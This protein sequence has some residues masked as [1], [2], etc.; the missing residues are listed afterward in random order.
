MKR[1]KILAAA[2]LSAVLGAQTLLMTACGTDKAEEK[3]NP[4]DGVSFEMSDIKNYKT[5]DNGAFSEYKNGATELSEYLPHQWEE[6]GAGDP[7]V[8]RYNGMYYLYVS[9]RDRE[10]GVMGWKSSDML[11]WAPCQGDG[12]R[13]GFVSEDP[14]TT[15]AYAPEVYYFNGKFYMATSPAGGGHY[16]LRAD[17]PEGPFTPIT[18]NYGLSIDGSFFV[19]DDESIYFLNAGTGGI[20]IN[21]MDDFTSTPQRKGATGAVASLGWTEGPMMIKRGDYYYLT[22][23]GS[24]V[25]SPGYKVCY[26]TVK[27]GQSIATA[28]AYQAGAGNPILLTVDTDN[29]FKGLGHSSTVLGPDM[30]SHYIIYHTLDMT[31]GHGPWRS[32]NIDRLIFNGTQMSV[33]SSKTDSVA[34]NLP[35]FAATGTTGDNAEKFETAG[36]MTLSKSAT[37]SVFTAEFNFKGNNVKN[38]VSYV[39]ENNYAYVQTDY[40]AKT[41]KLNKVTGG[42]AAEVASGTLKNDFDPDV[43]HTVRVAYADGKADVY[44][45]NMRKIKDVSVTLAAGKVGYEGGIEYA[46]TA[47]SNVARGYSDRKEL[48]QNDLAIG[49]S[50]YLPEGAYEGVQSYKFGARSG[51]SDVV[52]DKRVYVDDDK[53]HG[54]KQ[55]TLANNGDFASYATYFREGGHYGLYL[56]YDRQ[57]A[58][59][60]I[61]FQINGGELQ[62]VKLPVVNVDEEDYVSNIY[63]ACVGEFDVEKGANIIT[64]YGGDNGFA[65]ISFTTAKKAYGN[66]E[67]INDLSEAV[68][69]GALYSSMY[70]LAEG[71]HTT[72]SGNRML[73]YFGDGTLAD[74]EMEVRIRFLSENVYG[75]GVI[76]RADNYATSA[77]DDKNSIQGYYVG[78]D[79]RRLTLSKYNF[80]Y[81]ETN[82]R[83][84]DHGQSATLADHW[85]RLKVTFKGNTIT[86]ALDG[87][88]MFSFTDP[89]PFKAGYAGLYSDGAEVVYKNLIIR[90]I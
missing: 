15:S 51:V 90:G 29:N 2:V 63:T 57:Y 46:Y 12:L 16:T 25:T 13:E 24:Q 83:F 84:D 86:V 1:S 33:S 44:F 32:F 36:E 85:F 49:A 76:L 55:L 72:R 40:T 18:G 14:V 20:V 87:K 68:E 28:R 41:V 35:E 23:T 53:Y 6:Y 89:H 79:N 39:D 61:A 19:D 54:A 74:F 69:K 26:A 50:T 82:V 78:L 59:R 17:S 22:Y 38:I 71:G 65:F 52:V 81:T 60:S 45:D 21:S 64:L 11:H 58:G 88:T 47:F 66:Y 37:G 31:T 77:Y 27:E 5:Y 7:Y 34:A 9:T 4:I 62:Q 43:I 70:R 67:F 30:D 10:N 75:A 48:K 3:T 56:T 8:F 73:V 80:N 42:T